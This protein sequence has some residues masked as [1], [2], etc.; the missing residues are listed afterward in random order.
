LELRTLVW[1]FGLELQSSLGIGI[2]MEGRTKSH[3]IEGIMWLGP[4]GMCMQGSS[5]IS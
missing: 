5:F 1:E 4:S 3:V 2:A